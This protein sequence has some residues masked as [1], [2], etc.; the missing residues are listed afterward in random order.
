MSI[1]RK[2]F[3]AIAVIITGFSIITAIITTLSSSSAISEQIAAQKQQTA[4]RL[5]NI[6]TVTDALMH[7]RVVSSM[8]LLKQRGNELG[9]PSQG[10][11]IQVK[12]IPAKQ[13]FLGEK[14]QA[15]DFSLVDGLTSV[16]GG[17]ATLFSKTGNDFIRVSTNVINNGERAIGTKLAPQGKAMARIRNAEPYYGAVDILGSPYITGYEPMFD[18]NQQVI[19][20]WYVGYSADLNVLEQAIAQSRLLDDGF[21]AIKDSKGNLRMHSAHISSE[22]AGQI[23][24]AP[25]DEWEV[26]EVPFT[27]WGYTIILVAS[28]DEQSA[29]VTTALLTVLAK[30]ILASGALLATLYFLINYIVGKPLNEFITVVK[31]LASGDGDLTFR[32]DARRSDEFGQMAG[33]FNALLSQLQDTLQGVSSATET[34]HEQSRQLSAT[35]SQSSSTVSALTQETDAIGEALATLQRN[36]QAVTEHLHQSND[37]AGAADSDT[38]KSVGVLTATIKDIEAQAR[39]IDT[40]VQVISELAH[41]SEQISGVMDVIR[42]IAE[43]TNLLALNAAIEAARAGEQGRGF[44]VVADEVRSL[45][46]RTQSSTEEI[47]VMIERLQQGSRDATENMQKNKDNA[48]ATVATTQQAGQSLEQSLQAVATITE[49]NQ[50]ASNMAGNQATISEQVAQR[51]SRIQSV[52]AENYQYAQQVAQKCTELVDEIAGMQN[53]LKRYRF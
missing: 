2:F 18:A 4:D 16:M 6:L 28:N 26:T 33:A 53:K 30:I 19:G 17:T 1:Q 46:S 13:L 21:V 36:T 34:M 20:I 39:D 48:Y 37:A 9:I 52:G 42:N 8:K 51:L 50:Q 14:P 7:E 23:L 24:N 45:A 32:F 10:N 5:S 35:A 3:I 31:S 47:R 38:R 49:L 41:A 44:A 15:N 40:S 29:L 43:Q 12:Q 27:S 25:G 11:E 22:Q